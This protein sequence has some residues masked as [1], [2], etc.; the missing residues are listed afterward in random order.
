MLILAVLCFSLLT[1]G[2]TF[3]VQILTLTGIILFFI[4][5]LSFFSFH[6]SVEAFETLK[7]RRS[8]YNKVVGKGGYIVVRVT[9]SNQSSYRLKGVRVEDKYSGRGLSVEGSSNINV[10]NLEPLEAASFYYVL[11]AK[12]DGAFT[13]GPL[14]LSMSDRLK[15]LSVS[16]T[17][18][19]LSKVI[20][21]PTFVDVKSS[22]T[23]LGL[24]STLISL[25]EHVHEKSIMVGRGGEY[26]SSRE[27][28]PGDDTSFIDW[29]ATARRG[30]LHI[31][32]FE[33]RTSSRFLLVVDSG[34][35]MST[36]LKLEYVK[37][38]IM[39]LS[40][41]MSIIGDFYGLLI[42]SVSGVAFPTIY[43][44]YV[45][46]GTGAD[47]LYK[48]ITV[49][50]QLNPSGIPN[51]SDALSFI[52]G[53]LCPPLNL[54][55]ITDLEDF[56]RK[57]I[58]EAAKE[59]LSAGYSV[60]CIATPTH[61]FV[62][63][64]EIFE[65]GDVQSVVLGLDYLKMLRERASLPL[66]ALRSLGVEV[67]EVGPVDIFPRFLKVYKYAKALAGVHG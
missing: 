13:I 40:R 16:R 60:I 39:L 3:S 19:D 47:H 65:S 1:I 22:V 46:P 56:E 32:E 24:K 67:Y 58:L 31:K 50:S 30:K 59:A 27:Y 2:L 12:A 63:P 21:I 37:Q 4:I 43:P 51:F 14:V 54:I 36:G 64:G 11:K 53:K 15:L 55:F 34:K 28:I 7:V 8:V 48:V 18:M 10:L 44:R 66:K 62:Q 52:R 17:V 25:G 57:N 42:P 49:S 45:P 35:S 9:L 61:L 41:S 29:K 26:R 5:F 23:E 38:A 20:I 33:R 6:I